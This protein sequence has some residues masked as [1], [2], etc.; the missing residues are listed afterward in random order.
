MCVVRWCLANWDL[1]SSVLASAFLPKF[2]AYNILR[3][4]LRGF[5]KQRWQ[6]QRQRQEE[7]EEDEE[8][9]ILEEEE[10]E[11]Q[12]QLFPFWGSSNST[13]R[14][15]STTLY[16][17]AQQR[18]GGCTGTA[19]VKFG[20]PE[21]ALLAVQTLCGNPLPDGSIMGV[22]VRQIRCWT[23]L[24]NRTQNERKKNT[25]D[26]CGILKTSWWSEHVWTIIGFQLSKVQDF[27]HSMSHFY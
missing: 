9:K 1:W 6:P 19:Y 25:V 7:E 24:N 10:E 12:Q 15:T 8:E 13:T 16:E 18:Y 17:I 14:W 23:L 26:G 21:D 4:A 20:V 2:T 3:R 27:F 11:Q 5:E 22:Y